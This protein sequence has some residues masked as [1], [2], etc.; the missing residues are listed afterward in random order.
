MDQKSRVQQLVDDEKVIV[1]QSLLEISSLNNEISRINQ[2]LLELEN[3]GQLNQS[4]HYLTLT[5]PQEGYVFDLATTKA[6]YVS[7]LLNF[8]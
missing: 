6:N 7:A 5:S 2:E 4:I 1:S 8:C 3:R